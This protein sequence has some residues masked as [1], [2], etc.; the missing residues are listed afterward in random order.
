MSET[1][2][3]C[4]KHDVG[5]AGSTTGHNPFVCDVCSLRAE[6][7]KLQ[8]EKQRLKADIRTAEE[9]GIVYSKDEFYNVAINKRAEAAEQRVKVLEAAISWALGEGDSDF[10]TRNDVYGEYWWRTELR[11]RAYLGGNNG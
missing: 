6:L 5:F 3:V 1:I 8:E 7:A 4:G 11:N 9:L 2:N 10:R